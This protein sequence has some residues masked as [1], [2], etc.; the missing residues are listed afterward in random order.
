MTTTA[1][2]PSAAV[3]N[4]PSESGP[5][6][7][8]PANTPGVTNPN[9]SQTTI[10]QTICT[11]GWT[12]T[13]RP[14]E[15]YTERV[16]HL[17]A[18]SGGAVTYNGTTYEVH[19]FELADPFISHYELDHLIP[20]ELGGAPADP[21]NLWMEPYEPPKG[22]AAPGKG[23]Q[24]KDDVENAARSAVCAGRMTLVDAQRDI[25]SNWYALGQRLGVIP[26]G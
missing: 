22:A 13:V 10:G 16:K 2:T 26:A 4:A 12:A 8:D 19:G 24:T 18:G 23:S 6:L 1:S 25:A 17:E 9:V 7:P 3:T 21:R 11:S 15:S 20:L 14:P 5:I